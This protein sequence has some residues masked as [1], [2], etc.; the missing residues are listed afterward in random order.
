[1]SF[2][3]EINQDAVTVAPERAAT[4]PRVG[5]LR[6][7]ETSFNA[8]TRGAAL[9]GIQDA[10]RNREEA[11]RTALRNA[12][13]ENIPSL[14][15]QADDPFRF[16][17]DLG[18]DYIETAR[19]LESDVPEN[20][21]GATIDPRL[22]QRIRDYDKRIL[23]LRK[24][25]PDL[26]LETADELW[27]SIRT[28][29]Q[30]FERRA[31]SERKDLGGVIGEFAGGAIGAM[32]PNTDPLNVA[33]LSVGGAGR[34]AAVR[35]AGQAGAQGVVE[36]I[37]QITGVQEQR[38]LLGLD[39]GLSDAAMRV[40]AAMIGGAAVQGV[41]EVLVAGARRLF[42]PTR[43]DPVPDVPAPVREPL[44]ASDRV[45]TGVVPQDEA[46][47]ASVLVQRPQA[48]YDFMNEVSPLRGTRAGKARTLE[49]LKHVEAQLDTWEGPAP[50]AVPPKMDTAPARGLNEFARVPDLTGQAER[51]SIDAI[52][53]KVDPQ[54]MSRYDELA[55]AKAQARVQLAAATVDRDASLK[56][57]ARL[58]AIGDELAR[59]DAKIARAS[60]KNR[61]RLGKEREE[62]AA[63]QTAEQEAL[64]ITDTPSMA[65]IR[66][67][68]MGID[69]QMRDMAELVSRAYA[70]ARGKWTATEAD[71]DA[72]T[73]M[74]REGRKDVGPTA[75]SEAF[76]DNVQRTLVDDV[77][78]LA[79]RPADM[80]ADA[81]AADVVK[82]VLEKRA[83]AADEAI[84]TFRS[85]A[86]RIVKDAEKYDELDAAGKRAAREKAEA[87]G[88][89]PPG[90]YKVEGFDDPVDINDKLSIVDE[91]TGDVRTVSIRE[92]L[93]EQ[94]QREEDLKAVQSCSIR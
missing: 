7:F 68:I 57:A 53:R 61:K 24:E 41:G 83:D 89:L 39:H 33:T 28:E 72:I 15:Q 37:N 76:V 64:A 84:E 3:S 80:K 58:D 77:P 12:G 32:N 5:F 21:R 8:Q 86:A 48:Y 93:A 51:A 66:R 19:F 81:D 26:R 91:A 70:R 25:F 18:N 16:L 23:E 87:E 88:T 20:V 45:P 74:M 47:A 9:F 65:T 78:M 29:A 52:A 27:Q 10:M 50:W 85:E 71:R 92:M 75:E 2:F 59:I 73:A 34:T 90:K 49:D 22:Q 69:E 46:L 31:T 44:P 36:T 14:S 62:I 13:V 82:A 55:D 30:E 17:T 40:G 94:V 38:D 1:M 11:Q 35:I 43:H 54:T 67:R 42:R 63:R 4:G 79:E 56:G 6:A 60:A